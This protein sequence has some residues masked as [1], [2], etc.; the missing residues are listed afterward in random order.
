MTTADAGKNP[1][2]YL[3]GKTWH[4]S[5]G[6]R[7]NVALYWGMFTISEMANSVAEPVIYA[8]LFETLTVRGIGPQ[9]IKALLTCLALLFAANLVS[10]AF[11]GPARCLERDNSF[12]GR[13][14]YTAYLLGGSALASSPVAHRAS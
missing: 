8:R 6:N 13:L 4:Y 14:K 1:L 3:F 9:S 5:A 7:R 2:H 12:R 11:H 10:W